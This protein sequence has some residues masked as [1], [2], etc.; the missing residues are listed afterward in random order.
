MFVLGTAGHVDHGKS[1]LI[2]ALTGIHPDRLR[3]EQERGMTIELG[4]AWM[5]L[6][7][8]REVSIVDV[9]GHVRFVRHMLAGIGAIDLALFVV[10]A[11]EGVM[12]QTREH[13]AILDLLEVRHAVVA[14]TKADLVEPDWAA[15][16]AEEVREALAPTSL[17]GAPVVPVSSVT[18]AGLDDL[19]AALDAALD[20]VPEPRD[21]GR[22]RLG[23][24]R[25]FTMPGFGTV[26]TGTLLDGRLA[27]GDTVELTPGG[28]TA[29]I[30]GLQTHR[31]EVT[32]ALPGT[33]TAVN[34]AGVDTD[35]VARGQ[36]LARPG[37][38]ASVRAFD[39]R[40]RVLEGQTLRHNL[41]VAVHIGSAEV[42]ARARVLGGDAVEGP[43]EGWAQFILAE[44]VA[45]AT[46]DLFVYRVSDETVGGGRLLEV[47]PPR[48]RRTDPAVLARLAE[49]ARGTPE[50][51]LIAALERLEPAT[52]TALAGAVELERDAALT[53]IEALVAD[54]LVRSLAPATGEPLLLT[55]ARLDALRGEAVQRL[56]AYHAAHPLR[57]T[58]PREELR[59]GLGLGAREF[60]AILGGLAPEV[61]AAGDGVARAGWT[62]APPP[63]LAAQIEAAASA[64]EAGGLQP[65]RVPLDAEV[66]AYLEA[67]GRIVDCGDGVL[68]GAQVFETA[69]A[70]IV[71]ALRERGALSLAEVRDL[72][73]TNR[74]NAQAVLE[75]L[76]R[77]GVTRR[78]G[79]TRIL[80]GD[81]QG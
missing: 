2:Q 72:L 7:S 36:V 3:E 74:R 25:A 57:F 75:T 38:M 62:P 31:N 55:A 6:P 51:R 27:V 59:S 80:R 54:G 39:A 76:D 42:Q 46:G 66:Q 48:H 32:E 52:A 34:L 12:P 8:G 71:A 33:R 56:E 23:I 53:V 58:M 49:R 5:T 67:S 69:R 78:Q 64:I 50:S 11:D 17:A 60:P 26:V 18:G 35:E 41:R 10:A 63:P 13:L 61:V 28:R 21:I 44:P 70:R 16:V 15:L 77:Q 37:R 47:N 79:E 30:R 4:F 73:D 43:G 45:A 68:L 1:S 9:P 19:R 22:P 29:R 20:G 65:P 24:D 14:L 40:V 81:P